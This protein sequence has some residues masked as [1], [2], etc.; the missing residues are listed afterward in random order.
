MNIT[1]ELLELFVYFYTQNSRHAS[2]TRKMT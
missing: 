2:Q 1:V